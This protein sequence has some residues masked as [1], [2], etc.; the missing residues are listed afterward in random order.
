MFKQWT[1]T[2]DLG[3]AQKIA[4]AWAQ[5]HTGVGWSI[6]DDV[7]SPLPHFSESHW[8]RVLRNFLKSIGGRFRLDTT[9][10][11]PLQRAHD[12]YIM[13]HVLSSGRF[14]DKQIREVYYC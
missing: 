12:S 13:D 6:F 14:T 11:P 8:L 2:L 5:M 10:V 4:V 9:F 7:S 3:V 1:S